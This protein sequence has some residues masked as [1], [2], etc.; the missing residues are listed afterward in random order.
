MWEITSMSLKPYLRR[1][2]FA[3]GTV[4]SLYRY[5]RKWFFE[6]LISQLKKLIFSSRIYFLKCSTRI[7]EKIIY[8]NFKKIQKW[9]FRTL[10]FSFFSKVKLF[11]PINN[12][13]SDIL[14]CFFHWFSLSIPLDCIQ[15][16]LYFSFSCGFSRS[17]VSLSLSLYFSRSFSS[18]LC[19][20]FLHCLYCKSFDL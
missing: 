10:F 4:R 19:M 14:L 9:S 1:A 15:I 18:S 11:K 20:S 3:L 6:Q 16:F 5:T 2:V 8:L 17:F 13:N 12:N 7:W